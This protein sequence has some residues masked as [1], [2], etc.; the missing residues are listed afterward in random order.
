MIVDIDL[1]HEGDSIYYDPFGKYHIF[2]HVPVHVKPSFRVFPSDAN[3]GS[4]SLTAVYNGDIVS[5]VPRADKVQKY[6][7]PSPF[8]TWTI[9]IR[10]VDMNA[11]D[12]SEVTRAWFG[13]FGHKP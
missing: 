8:A 7:G 1:T 11:V 3:G 9:S 6:A 10:N 5:R 2:S 13:F 12:L 4:A